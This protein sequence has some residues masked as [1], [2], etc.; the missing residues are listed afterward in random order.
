MIEQTP[1]VHDIKVNPTYSVMYKRELKQ[2]GETSYRSQ[3]L[4]KKKT[5]KQVENE[6]N[7]RNND[8]NG[9]LSEK[10]TKKLKNAINW[11]VLS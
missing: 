4:F 2:A 8:T 3:T 5:D 1:Y 11:L 9:K 7:L 6:Q 10:A